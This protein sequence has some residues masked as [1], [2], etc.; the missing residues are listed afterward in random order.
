MATNNSATTNPAT[1][2]QITVLERDEGKN[3]HFLNNLATIKVTADSSGSMSAV[4]FLSP[5]GFGPPLH[6]HRDEDELVVVL[7]G[8]VEFRSGDNT[9]VAKAGACA[10]LPHGIPHTFQVLSPTARMLSVTS[11]AGLAPRFDRMV[12]ALGTPADTPII[13]PQTEV[14][15]GPVALINAEHGIDVLGPPPAPLPD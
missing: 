4:E 13:P 11:S 7:D 5:R 3:L 12:A 1:N 14:D 8:E 9:T 2:E 15:P 10:Y 6:C